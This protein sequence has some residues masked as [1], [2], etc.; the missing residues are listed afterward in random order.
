MQ[1]RPRLAVSRE[2]DVGHF[3]TL[4][5]RP[6]T[7]GRASAGCTSVMAGSQ[8]SIAQQLRASRRTYA[9][10]FPTLY[11]LNTLSHLFEGIL[12]LL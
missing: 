4:E 7:R 8:I 10:I 12:R 3:G 2:L 5:G 11:L 1:R 6:G 9:D